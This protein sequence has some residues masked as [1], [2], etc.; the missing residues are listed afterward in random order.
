MVP[1]PAEVFLLEDERSQEMTLPASSFQK[2]LFISL[3]RKK[4][5]SREGG[6]SQ[7]DE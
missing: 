1:I 3:G 5:L 2:R 4:F 6:L 7:M